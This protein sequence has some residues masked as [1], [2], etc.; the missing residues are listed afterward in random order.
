MHEQT[1]GRLDG[2]RQLRGHGALSR[3]TAWREPGIDVTLFKDE[4]GIEL[5]LEFDGGNRD[6]MGWVTET[7]E[8]PIENFT[9]IRDHDLLDE[10][11]LASFAELPTSGAY[12]FNAWHEAWGEHKWF[13]CDPDDAQAKELAF[14]FGKPAEGIFRLNSIYPQDGFW[15]NSQLRITPA[16]P[17]GPHFMEHY[18]HAVAELDALRITRG[19]LFMDKA[20]TEE[21]AKFAKVRAAGRYIA[22]LDRMEQRIRA[23]MADGRFAFLRRALT[24]YHARKCRELAGK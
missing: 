8:Q 17:A 4:P 20:H 3:D 18:A 7:A 12:I 10:E 5:D 9:V 21:I 22:G 11:T 16:F 2:G 19:G 15:W 1:Q 24:G 6:R 14:V 13:R 23:A